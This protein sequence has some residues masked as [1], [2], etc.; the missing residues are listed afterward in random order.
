MS[1]DPK[2]QIPD[3]TSTDSLEGH[4]RRLYDDV[5]TIRFQEIYYYTMQRRMQ[6]QERILDILLA[7]SSALLIPLITFAQILPSIL[8]ASEIVLLAMAKPL[9]NY[10]D[11]QGKAVSLASRLG[12]VRATLERVVEHVA[13]NH[14]LTDGDRSIVDNAGLEWRSTQWLEDPFQ[15]NRHLLE[16]IQ[17]DVRKEYPVEN[18]WLPQAR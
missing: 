3:L 13:Q 18:F 16:R 17:A 8:V 2:D 1:E 12:V 4:L 14:E 5:R 11:R 6:R 9:L 15:P 10:S 7:L